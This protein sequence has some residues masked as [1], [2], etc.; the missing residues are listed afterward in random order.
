MIIIKILKCLSLE[1]QALGL[2]TL[3]KAKDL[4]YTINMND[5]TCLSHQF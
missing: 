5:G 3:L 1:H 4:A 2:I